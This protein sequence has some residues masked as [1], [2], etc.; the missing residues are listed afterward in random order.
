MIEYGRMV[1]VQQILTNAAREGARQA[2]LD[3]STVL[4]VETTVDNFLDNATV[5]GATITVT[6]NPLSD[7]EFGDPVTVQVEIAFTQVSWLPSPMFLGTTN[8]SATTV[9]RRESVQ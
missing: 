1:M 3:G 6:P 2:V 7:A 4:E 5:S 9:M 8:L